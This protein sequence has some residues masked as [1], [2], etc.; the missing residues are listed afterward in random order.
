MISLNDESKLKV[1]ESNLT[2]RIRETKDG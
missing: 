1:F 2:T